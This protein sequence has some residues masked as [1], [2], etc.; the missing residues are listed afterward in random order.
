MTA[1]IPELRR[2]AAVDHSLMPEQRDA[3]TAVLDAG[4]A[5]AAAIVDHDWWID[6]PGELRAAL[7]R[8]RELTGE[9]EAKT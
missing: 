7:A 1:P 9:N 2:L 5:M 3:L 6:A 8:W 4:E